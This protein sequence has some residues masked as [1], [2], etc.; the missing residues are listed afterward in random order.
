MMRS[1]RAV[2]A[3]VLTLAVGTLSSSVLAEEKDAPEFRANAVLKMQ[4]TDHPLMALRGRLVLITFFAPWSE[5]CA[6]AV[7]HLNKTRNRWGGHG[8]TIL[9]VAEGTMDQLE[10]WVAEHGVE[11]AV[12][13]VDALEYEKVANGFSVPG[14]PHAALVSPAGKVV[15]AGHPQ[16][17]KDGGIEAHIKG[18]K[19]PP[20]TLPTALAD[21]QAMLD[22]G[23]WAEA[24]TSLREVR[25]SLDKISKRWA[26]GLIS[27][28]DARRA[29]WLSD[30][31]ALEAEG[32]YWDAWDMY[33]DFGR[34]FAAME[35][36]EDA[37]ARAEA[38]RANPEAKKDLAAGDDVRKAKGL[39]ANG[40][41]RPAQLILKRVIKQAKKTVHAQRAKALLD[42]M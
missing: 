5:R 17:L 11:Y 9:A 40:K 7:P 36:A 4:E 38:L 35:G 22:D 14:L 1:L 37:A 34:R 42:G 13:S 33:A 21:Q 27:W 20:S 31:A 25:D 26:D 29:S 15:W 3:V 24:Q 23:R 12:A 30:A 18:I 16:S 8:L 2:A 39:L 28:V 10:P 6:T 32:R 41:T 19:L